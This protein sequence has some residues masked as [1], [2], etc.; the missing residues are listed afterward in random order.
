MYS[1]NELIQ[2]ICSYCFCI[3][4]LLFLVVYFTTLS[5]NLVASDDDDKHSWQGE[6]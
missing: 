1:V 6:F 5:D 4:F 2:E 3:K